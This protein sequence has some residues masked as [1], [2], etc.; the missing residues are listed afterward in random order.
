[1]RRKGYQFKHA[2][3]LTFRPAQE[4]D[5]EQHTGEHKPTWDDRQSAYCVIVPV[6]RCLDE[7]GRFSHELREQAKC[8]PFDGW[9][10]TNML[11]GGVWRKQTRGTHFWVRLSELPLEERAQWLKSEAER[12]NQV[13]WDDDTKVD[14]R[15]AKWFAVYWTRTTYWVEDAAVYTAT[16]A[17]KD[18]PHAE[19]QAA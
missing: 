3:H 13:H 16:T 19:Q 17:I 10:R 12:G 2:P 1:M 14:G 7:D 6:K 18:N 4:R 11:Y 5:L 8:L 15:V 9:S